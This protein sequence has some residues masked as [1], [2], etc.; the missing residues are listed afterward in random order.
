MVSETSVQCSYNLFIRKYFLV[1]LRKL[2]GLQQTSL[3]VDKFLIGESEY[4]FSLPVSSPST[5][6]L[7]HPYLPSEFPMSTS[8]NTTFR[9]GSAYTVSA[10]HDQMRH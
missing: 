2:L 10:K 6:R 8:H 1:L 5:C 9:N 3:L 7:T 4:I